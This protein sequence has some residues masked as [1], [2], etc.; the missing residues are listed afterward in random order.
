MLNGTD[1]SNLR[2]LQGKLHIVF[3][4]QV[5][6]YLC[7]RCPKGL[8]ILR[9]T[10]D[11]TAQNLFQSGT[12]QPSCYLFYHTIHGKITAS[13]FTAG[14]PHNALGFF[15]LFFCHNKKHR[16]NPQSLSW[17]IYEV[18][19]C[20]KCL[21]L[22]G[23]GE[24]SRHTRFYISGSLFFTWPYKISSD[25]KGHVHI[26]SALF[27]SPFPLLQQPGKSSKGCFLLLLF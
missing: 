26:P 11:R 21:A 23:R 20:L 3:Q 14:L 10:W 7:S 22:R 5:K 9:A 25:E 24:S 8:L 18:S 16:T 15:C 4:G 13:V 19:N 17:V 6:I 2:V 27:K 12:K 1:I